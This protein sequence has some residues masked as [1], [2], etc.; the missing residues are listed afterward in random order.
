[1]HARVTSRKRADWV[2]GTGWHR[3]EKVPA[4]PIYDLFFISSRGGNF[5]AHSVALGGCGVPL[6]VHDDA[7]YSF[8]IWHLVHF[9]RFISDHVYSVHRSVWMSKDF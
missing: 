5:N 3:Y 7:G 2:G 4:V 6:K 9:G 8:F 1:V